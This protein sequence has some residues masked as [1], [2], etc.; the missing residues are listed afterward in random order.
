MSCGVNM[1]LKLRSK[2]QRL[3]KVHKLPNTDVTDTI[4][5]R[6]VGST[7]YIVHIQYAR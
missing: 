3:L 6:Y 4:P 7:V 5:L 1:M 2:S